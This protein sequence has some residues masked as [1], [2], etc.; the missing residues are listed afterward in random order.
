MSKLL[1]GTYSGNKESEDEMRKGIVMCP[2]HGDNETT[3]YCPNCRFYQIAHTQAMGDKWH[4]PG[5]C[6]Q[7]DAV[8]QMIEDKRMETREYKL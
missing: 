2:V 4:K 6:D 1:L 7:C 8:R 3:S 5:T